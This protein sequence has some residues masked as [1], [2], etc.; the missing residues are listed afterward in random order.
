MNIKFGVGT[1]GDSEAM[2]GIGKCFRMKHDMSN[3]ELIVQSINTGG[4]VSGNQF[5]LTQGDGGTGIFN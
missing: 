3:T 4:D 5:D 2:K 1:Y